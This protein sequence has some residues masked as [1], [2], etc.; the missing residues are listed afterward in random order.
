MGSLYRTILKR[1]LKLS[2]KNKWLWLFGFFAAILGQGGVYEYLFKSFDNLTAGQSVL[3]TMQEYANGGILG[4]I[5]FG[6][7]QSVWATDLSGMALGIFTLLFAICVIALIISLAVIGQGGLVKSII[8]LDQ[9]KKTTPK[10]CFSVG[11]KKFWP[12]LEL[13]FI[14]KVVL[15]GV[16]MLLTYFA[17]LLMQQIV[18]ID[19]VIFVL[20]FILFIVL[21]III[22]FLTLYGTAYIVLRDKGLLS[23]LQSAW[24]LFRRN[25]VIN[26]EMGLLIFVMNAIVAVLAVITLFILFAPFI[27]VFFV[28]LISN[29]WWLINAMNVLMILLFVI[30]LAL[31]TGWYTTFVVSCWMML[32]EQLAMKGGKSKLQ[33]VYE[34]V[35]SKSKKK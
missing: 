23:A 11:V 2:W 25:V 17:A 32:F 3:A 28:V 12:I 27:I 24:H 35:T 33:R 15:M 20:F 9:G 14:T 13:N 8:T 19:T 18:A 34:K 16:L 1:A 6:R 26:L 5:S 29:I 10:E 22:Y 31:A 4:M 7:L 30:F 21:G